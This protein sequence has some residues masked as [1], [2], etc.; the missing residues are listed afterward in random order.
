MSEQPLPTDYKIKDV[1]EDE[2]QHD[3]YQINLLSQDEVLLYKRKYQDI[4]FI[5]SKTYFF[6]IKS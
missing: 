3:S 6:I 4:N 5:A 1:M 2:Y